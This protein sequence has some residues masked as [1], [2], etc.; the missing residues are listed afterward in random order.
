MKRELDIL[1][2]IENGRKIL[3]EY[4]GCDQDLNAW[5]SAKRRKVEFV[6]VFTEALSLGLEKVR[7]RADNAIASTSSEYRDIVDRHTV[8]GSSDSDD[9]DDEA[10]TPLRSQPPSPA[11]PLA[12]TSQPTPP[13][14][15]QPP[16]HR[17]TAERIWSNKYDSLQCHKIIHL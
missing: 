13:L 15:L 6:E 7:S 2:Q 16:P 11:P 1:D 10:N 17:Y 5:N 14:A 3:V 9:D 8:Y 12:S 4:G